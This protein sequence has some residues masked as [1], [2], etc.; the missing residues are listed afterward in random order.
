MRPFVLRT[1]LASLTL[2]LSA[3]AAE[4]PSS[5]V[6]EPTE[7]SQEAIVGGSVEPGLDA[8]VA[9]FSNSGGVCS[10]TIIAKN[11]STGYVLT[12][13][14]C[15]NM[16]FVIQADDYND[17]FGQGNSECQAVYEVAEQIY[18]PQY[19]NNAPENGYDFSLI[20][21]T[22]ANA[23]TPVI[24]AAQPSDGVSGSSSGLLA[25]GYG[26]TSGV[27]QA[28]NSL[29]RSVSFDVDQLTSIFIVDDQTDGKGSCS[30]DSGGPALFNNAV[31]GVVSFGDQ[32][33]TQ[34]GAYGRVQAVYNNFIAPFI[35][36]MSPPETC[37]SCF[38]SEVNSPGGACASTVEA[39]FNDTSCAA[40]VDCVQNCTTDACVQGC[41]E[42][43]ANG[44]AKYNAIF[45]CWCQACADVCT[46]ECG[47]SSTSATTSTG[48]GAGNGT[49]TGA[50]GSTGDGGA[51]GDGGNG[52][53]DGGDGG[54]ETTTVTECACST[55][56]ARGA[57]PF[58]VAGALGLAL[59]ALARRR[60]R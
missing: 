15:E 11:G 37:D 3:C 33:C 8:V 21:F 1:G 49:T 42:Q 12:A 60:R 54:G 51:T 41:A 31:V 56:G 29:R 27:T 32:N 26:I 57:S 6:D 30:G 9:L 38:D 28:N 17:C 14:H 44:V 16:D 4:E 48:S 39:C 53:S 5:S 13:A 55:P 46:A 2:A 19:N 58:A 20:R 18:H 7:S 10:G 34:I 47:G 22:G 35:G 40:L 24:P 59:G 52:G 25:V 45:E 50:G 36:G 23:S 43:H